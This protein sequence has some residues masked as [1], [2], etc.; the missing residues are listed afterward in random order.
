MADRADVCVVGLG[1]VGLPTALLAARAG[2]SVIGAERD[3][4]LRA[5]IEAPPEHPSPEPGLDDLAREV[6]RSGRL[7]VVARPEAART[8][9]V[10]VGTPVGSDRRPDLSD[11]DAALDAVDAV[12]PPDG[13]VVLA[14]T[15][16]VGATA[17]AAGRLRA[18]AP[19]RLVACCPERVMPGRLVEE[20]RSAPRIAGGVDAAST[21]AAVAWL[22][23]FSSGPVQA[24]TS[25]A[26][27]LTKLVENASRDVDL[28]FAH[29]V[30]SLAE[31]Y[32]LDA[33]E[34][35]ALASQHPRVR[36]LSPGIGVGGHCIP[37]D[38]WFLVADAPEQTRLLSLAREI[39]DAVPEHWVSAIASRARQG[40]RVG[41]LG[42]AYKP[43]TDDLRASP[44]LQIARSLARRFEVLVHDPYAQPPPDLR[45][46]ALDEVLA[47][48]LVVLLVAHSAYA[49]LGARL[50]PERRLDCCRGWS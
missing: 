37:V 47:C 10:C 50:P 2:M 4:E 22:R 7:R 49:A 36:L 35:V 1:R 12:A 46:G 6:A 16:P 33:H 20:M 41:L 38:P 42:L 17:R 30:A 19:A 48:D 5:R 21:D 40:D 8:T 44:A 39:N 9:V 27:E 11:L 18:R 25:R 29:T 31:R 14:S 45:R 26:A 3:P 23:S 24:T 28:A 43:E 32:E 13:L 15:V 34:I